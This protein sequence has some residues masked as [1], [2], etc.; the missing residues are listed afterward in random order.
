MSQNLI[1]I[2]EALNLPNTIFIDVRSED[3]FSKSCIPGAINIPILKN[4]ERVTVGKAYRNTSI[5]EAKSLGLKY[6][7]YK[8]QDYYNK[9]L[10]L[11]A[12]YDN[13]IIYCWRGGI[14]SRSVCSLLNTIGIENIYQLSGGYKSYRNFVF[15]FLETDVEK[16]KFIVLHGLT[17]V[18][19]TI[20]IDRLE[21]MNIPIVNLEK[22]A[23]NSGSVFGDIL[24]EGSPPTQ[25]Q[26]ESILFNS[27]YHSRNKYIVVESESKRIGS[28]NIPDSVI[29][30]MEDGY[31]L[32][33]ETNLS[34]RIHNIYDEYVKRDL[35]I[36]DRLIKCIDHLNKGLG[37]KNVEM[38]VEKIN[39]SDYA[40]VIEFLIKHYYDPLYKY[41]ISKFDRFDLSINYDNI[42]SA[43]LLIKQFIDEH[44]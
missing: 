43:V 40:F 13:I 37:N 23:K 1:S 30:A 16:Y 34:N 35:A 24:F 9:V 36:N 7:S 44:I 42:D 39:N 32:L 12:A 2:E 41:S 11:R 10:E 28:I 15:N 8:L 17:G 33:I 20:I 31:H 22:L 21:A 26:F 6:A 5:E 14:R 4:E 19:K 25:K 3:E 29:K 27:L 38:L 18:G